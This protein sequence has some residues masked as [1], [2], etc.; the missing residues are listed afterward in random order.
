MESNII[1]S[2]QV[3]RSICIGLL[4]FLRLLWIPQGPPKAATYDCLGN[5][6]D[7]PEITLYS[8]YV[9]KVHSTV[10]YSPL[11]DEKRLE[12][13]P[14]RGDRGAAHTHHLFFRL[15]TQA[16]VLLSVNTHYPTELNLSDRCST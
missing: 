4:S 14:V 9:A 10:C 8:S 5:H 15:T 1:I 13:T 7:R 11:S 6:A 16:E 3:F 2:L 12:P